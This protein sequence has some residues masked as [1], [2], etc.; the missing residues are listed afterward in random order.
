MYYTLAI[1][2]VICLN[3]IYSVY[4]VYY[5]CD[6]IIRVADYSCLKFGLLY[7]IDFNFEIEVLRTNGETGMVNV[8][9]ILF[10]S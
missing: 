5:T 9:M 2:V 1:F 7:Y 4:A 6:D 3:S 10:R 8:L